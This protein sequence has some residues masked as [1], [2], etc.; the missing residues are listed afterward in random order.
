MQLTFHRY[1]LKLRHN[2]VV[3]SSQKI[4]GRKIAPIVLLELRDEDGVVSYGEAASSL[5]YG[6]NAETSVAFLR[7]IDISRL[8]F[9]DVDASRGYVESVSPN[10]YSAKGALDI[11][12]VDGAAKKAQQSLHDFFGLQFEEGK[13]V[14]SVS[15]GID[16]PAAIRAKAEELASYPILKLKVGSPNDRENLSALREVAPR[17]TLRVDANEAWTTKEE[18]LR[19]IEEFAED[20]HLELIEQ[21]MPVG[22]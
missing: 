12:L 15:I 19:H 14:S 13:R 17:K 4:G 11:A 3:A 22:K 10:D 20:R 16:E 21:P 7:K 8:S 5:R 9:D 18:A 2:W 1:D 6:E